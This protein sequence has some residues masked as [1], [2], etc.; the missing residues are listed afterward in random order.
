MKKTPHILTSKTMAIL[1]Y[2][3]L[4]TTILMVFDAIRSINHDRMVAAKL[5]QKLHVDTLA[6]R[7]VTI[8]YIHSLARDTR[9]EYLPKI[10]SALQRV[11]QS[12][13]ELEPLLAAG[14]EQS[15]YEAFKHN[16]TAYLRD[17]NTML[18]LAKNNPNPQAIT[19]ITGQTRNRYEESR[20][21]L[22]KLIETNRRYPAS[23]SDLFNVF[24]GTNRLAFTFM[25]ICAV[26]A[27][28][29]W[30]FNFYIKVK[31]RKN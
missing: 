4:L 25:Y 3:F 1:F 9:R 26:T 30:A 23:W 22:D 10:M 15:V 11:E 16:W 12:Q 5:L 8:E 14:A 28:L 17:S 6:Y 13:R 19:A 29:I 7:L 27:F 31:K 20:K 2:L 18:A 21:M 24:F